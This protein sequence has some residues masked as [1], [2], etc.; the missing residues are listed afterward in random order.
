MLDYSQVVSKPKWMFLIQ[1][2]EESI[3]YAN[4]QNYESVSKYIHTTPK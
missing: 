3:N 4:R 2:K 1:H